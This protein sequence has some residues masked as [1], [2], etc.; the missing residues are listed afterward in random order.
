M[1]VFQVHRQFVYLQ[2]YNYTEIKHFISLY[3]L[4]KPNQ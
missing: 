3:P 2:I 4:L 1:D